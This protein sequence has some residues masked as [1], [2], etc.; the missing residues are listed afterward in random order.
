MI[1]EKMRLQNTYSNGV[2]PKNPGQGAGVLGTLE[3]RLP[4]TSS[5]LNRGIV[6]AKKTVDPLAYYCA[7][8]LIIGMDEMVTGG[9]YC[10]VGGRRCLDLGETIRA[11]NELEAGQ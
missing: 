8:V 1:G 11:W 4:K 3:A 2:A 6:E 7:F 10:Q 5:T 9:G